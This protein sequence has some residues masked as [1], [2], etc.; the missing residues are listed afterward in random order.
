MSRLDAETR[1]DGGKVPVLLEDA[2][3]QAAL[4]DMQDA[5]FCESQKWQEQQW[6]ADRTGVPL[7]LCEFGE[8]FINRAKKMYSI[9]LFCHTA[10]RTREEQLRL[11]E[12]GFSKS[13]FGPHTHGLALDIIHSTKAWN[14]SKNQ[15]ALLG[16]IGCEVAKDVLIKLEWGGNWSN[17]Y[18]PAHWQIAQWRQRVKR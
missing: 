15:W 7:D 8:R 1:A 17:P 6:R 9:P 3:L 11:V 5:E 12:Q 10:R 4:V 13:P 18:D 16:H 2:S 14:L